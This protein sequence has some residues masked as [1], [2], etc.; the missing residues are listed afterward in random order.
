MTKLHD[1]KAAIEL[2]KS[3]LSY[4]EIRAKIPVS[5]SSLSLW[6]RSVGLAKRHARRITDKQRESQKKGVAA[7]RQKRIDKTERIKK[8]AMSQITSLSKKER[9]LIGI[10]LYW[11]EGSKERGRSTRVIFSNSDPNMIIFF[12]EWILDFLE[13][14]PGDIV[15]ALS[16]HEKSPG[17]AHAIRFW[18]T[19]LRIEPHELRLHLK[20]H[21]PSPKRKNIGVNY[22]GLIR[23][24]INKSVDMNR[25]IAG[26]VDGIVARQEIIGE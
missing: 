25:K 5:K 4:N 23:L 22:K 21:N 14:D 13:V 19:L 16:I 11:A 10:A 7:W 20:R 9:W 17:I 1:R 2:R 18:C 12:R 26:W 15:Y 24:A 6:L 3:G 8:E